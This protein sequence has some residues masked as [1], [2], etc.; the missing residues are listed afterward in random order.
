MNEVLPQLDEL[1]FPSADGVS[2]VSVEVTDTIVR[3]EAR[4][5]TKRAACPD[6]ANWSRRIHGS[7]LRFPRDLPAVGKLV[8]VSLRVR[9]FVCA[10]ESC[11]RRTFAEQVPGLTRRFGRRTERLRSLLISVGLALAGRAGARMTS[12]FEMPVSR[13]TLLR[14]IASLPDPPA[15]TPRVVGVD[16]YAQ[17]RG[18]I[19]GTVL[20]DV[21]THRPVDLLPDRE[22]GTLAA[23]LVERPG[24]E[25]VCRDRATFFA[26]GATRGAPQA[27]QV[28]D[29]WHLW[30]NLSEAAEKCV[31][32][33]RSCLRSA[34]R[35]PDQEHEQAE[36]VGSSPWPTG[37]RFAERTRAKHA[38]IHALLVA[39]HSK[40]SVS[41]Q[42]GMTLNTILRFSRAATPEEMFTG[43]W[44]S[45]ATKLDA[46]KPY[47]D[48]RWQEGCTN[49][50]KLWE[51]ISEQGYPDGYFNVRTYVS[52]VLRGKPQPVGPRPPSARAVTRWILTHPDALVESDRLRLKAVLASCPE[53]ATL[54][55]HVRSF[56]HMVT[57]LRG[58][59]LPEW[60]ASARS[61]TDLISLSR[62][63]QHLE[64]DL[65]AVIAGL[66][67][68]WN[69]GV[70]EG[71][72]NRIKM[73]KR[74]MFG[75]AGFELLRKRVL[76]A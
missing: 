46:Y 13:N 58:E 26:E 69:S 14:L 65:D 60:I 75:R 57:D 72:V 2:V 19:Y 59:Q 62:F 11:P 70:V 29:R 10:E 55:E 25:I 9:R 44:Q 50:W 5:T 54:A 35:A 21:E 27:L 68:P 7:Y 71:H 3:V 32:Q 48:Q 12:A 42:L 33:H 22:A 41:R 76:L 43:Q 53:L 47:L 20:V 16:E 36:P 17:R 39:G 52:R 18:R 1:L 31:Y 51:E 73:L 30:H 34:P 4:T 24:I 56:A 49:A 23:W 64:R 61:T 6:C 74:Q 28:A 8:E 37:Q 15:A 40:R 45:R 66:T 63:A 38:T 67:Q